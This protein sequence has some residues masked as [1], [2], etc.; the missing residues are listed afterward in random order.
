MKVRFR[1]AT[2]I[3]KVV[4]TGGDYSAQLAEATE[5]MGES[6]TVFATTL[7]AT[8]GAASGAAT[9]TA[10]LAATTDAA[11]ADSGTPTMSISTES[12]NVAAPTQ[13]GI[14]NN[15]VALMAAAAVF[16]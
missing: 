9:P 15:M 4:P 7:D 2:R 3:V 1:P 14:A 12:E 6:G 8:V 5:S 13:V 11:N 16:I 10:T